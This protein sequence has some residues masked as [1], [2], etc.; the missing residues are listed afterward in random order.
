MALVPYTNRKRAYGY[1]FDPAPAS[2]IV[3]RSRYT[4]VPGY[5]RGNLYS[6]RRGGRYGR[7]GYR[8]PFSNRSQHMNPVYPRPE[9]KALDSNAPVANIDNAGTLIFLLNG[10]VS[11]TG[12]TERIGNQISTK[13][14]YWQYVLNFGTGPVPN[15]IRHILFWDKQP[16]ATQPAATDLLAQDT[17]GGNLLTAPL[18]LTNRDRFVILADERTTLSPNGDQIRIMTGF[19][20]INQRTTYP[21]PA[22]GSVNDFP[23]T[24]ALFALFISDETVTANE[25]NVYGTWRVRYIDC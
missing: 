3:K 6:N 21:A 4:M 5:A 7:R 12:L 22:D 11:G 16:N 1:A 9:V 18:N 2:S 15:A 10:L 24:G 14:V 8:S 19:R 20:N 17:T 13:S 23:S 25:P